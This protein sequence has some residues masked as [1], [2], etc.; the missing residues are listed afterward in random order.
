MHMHTHACTHAHVA[1]G[2]GGIKWLGRRVVTTV[3]P[4]PDYYLAEA[5]VTHTQ[6]RQRM[7]H[8]TASSVRAANS[9]RAPASQ[10]RMPAALC[11]PSAWRRYHQQYLERGGRFGSPQSA[12]KG[13]NDP[14]RCY[15]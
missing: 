12:S 1:Q 3:E 9:R 7:R 2:L 14:I 8:T 13:C 6:H 11:T 15:G 10:P 4:C 5:C